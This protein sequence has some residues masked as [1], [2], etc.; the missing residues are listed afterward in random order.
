MGPDQERVDKPTK[1][2]LRVLRE[3]RE[4]MFQTFRITCACRAWCAY[5]KPF[6]PPKKLSVIRNYYNRNQLAGYLYVMMKH[7]MN[8]G[9][10]NPDGYITSFETVNDLTKKGAVEVLF[11]VSYHWKQKVLERNGYKTDLLS[12]KQ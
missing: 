9:T 8:M 3:Q 5:D 10:Q 2:H 11:I 1:L 12:G 7:N 4:A 6:Q